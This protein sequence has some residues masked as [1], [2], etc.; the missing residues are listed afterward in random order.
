MFLKPIL[1]CITLT[2]GNTGPYLEV[3]QTG[4]FN[5][6]EVIKVETKVL[7]KPNIFFYFDG[8]AIKATLI[9]QSRWC[10]VPIK[11]LILELN[12]SL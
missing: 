7:K 1:N 5:L 3:G 8:F 9:K 4:E 10:L 11:S 6:R 12:L 2:H